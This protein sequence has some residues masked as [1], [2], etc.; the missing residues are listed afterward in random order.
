MTRFYPDRLK[1]L[2]VQKANTEHPYYLVPNE[3]DDQQPYK[4]YQRLLEDG[5]Q[6]AL[7]DDVI[8]ISAPVR[9]VHGLND[10][11]V[12]WQRSQAVMQRLSTQNASLALIK[13][14]DHRLSSASDLNMIESALLQLL[15]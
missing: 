12:G 3:Y 1:H 6:W 2:T 5:E 9:L 7:L 11:V 15:R 10:E 8:P 13:N 14:G 4:V